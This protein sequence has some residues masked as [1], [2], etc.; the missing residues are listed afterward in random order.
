MESRKRANKTNMVQTK[1]IQTQANKKQK[2]DF[3]LNILILI[4]S[5]CNVMFSLNF[6]FIFEIFMLGVS[7]IWNEKLF[8]LFSGLW[9]NSYMMRTLHGTFF[10]DVIQCSL[11]NLQRFGK[12]GCFLR[13]FRIAQ[14]TFWNF[15]AIFFMDLY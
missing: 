5:L 3:Q 13:V 9:D 8:L 15:I 6:Y 2:A 4:L 1:Q 14:R 10:R 11:W 7:L 12:G